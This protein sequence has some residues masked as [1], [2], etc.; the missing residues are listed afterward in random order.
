MSSAAAALVNAVAGHAL[1][2]D[3]VGMAGHPSTV[4]MPALWAEHERSGTSGF[5]LA[6]IR[7]QGYAHSRGQKIAGA[8][9]LSAPIFNAGGAI[10]ALCI[11][12]PDSRFKD[13]MLPKL[14]RTLIEQASR[15]SSTLG[16]PA[17]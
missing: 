7:A 12:L 10:G 9:G 15:L 17:R 6:Q 5:D 14:S 4:L 11:T 2:Y 16:A 13:S 8:V 3:D 1:D